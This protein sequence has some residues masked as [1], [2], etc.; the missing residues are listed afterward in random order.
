MATTLK[1]QF[2]DKYSQNSRIFIETGSYKGEGLE[3]ALNFS[4]EKLYSIELH[5]SLYEECLK[6]FK[7][8]N[9]VELFYGDSGTILFN[10]INHINNKIT[11]W[12]DGHFS[13]DHTAKGIKISPIMEELEQIKNHSINYHTIMID[14]IRYV[15]QGYYEMTMIDII[16]KIKEINNNYNIIFEDG[17]EKNDILI[18]YI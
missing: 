12:L 16:K 18:A 11:F 15:K 7:D 8:N 2:F 13:G 10:I 3:E 4:F 1:K 9:K 6:K 17:V 5:K 14:D